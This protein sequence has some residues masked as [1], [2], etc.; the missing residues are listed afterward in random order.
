MNIHP[1][2][3][4]VVRRRCAGLR[5]PAALALACAGTLVVGGSSSRRRCLPGAASAAEHP[6]FAASYL[7]GVSGPRPER[8]A[9]LAGELGLHPGHRTRCASEVARSAPPPAR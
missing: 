3:P 6:T 2:P 9:S 1:D 7:N 8:T 4:N 5:W